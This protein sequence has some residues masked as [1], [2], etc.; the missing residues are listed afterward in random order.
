MCFLEKKTKEHFFLFSPQ[1]KKCQICVVCHSIFL[2]ESLVPPQCP[3]L[4]LIWQSRRKRGGFSSHCRTFGQSV[5]GV[6]LA[7]TRKETV[8]QKSCSSAS[9]GA[10]FICSWM[11][12]STRTFTPHLTRLV[13]RDSRMKRKREKNNTGKKNQERIKVQCSFCPPF[14]SEALPS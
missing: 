2:P 14:T 11:S 10:P 9:H 7:E 6:L 13:S 5:F 3:L 4:Y 1:R 8:S 12:P